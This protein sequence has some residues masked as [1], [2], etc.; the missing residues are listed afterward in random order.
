MRDRIDTLEAQLAE[1]RADRER[2]D[3]L[4]TGAGVKIDASP[5]DH[6]Y[7]WVPGRGETLRD[8]IDA[9]REDK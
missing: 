3:W 2:L 6:R 9:A 8:A 7:H 5:W 1:A 4:E